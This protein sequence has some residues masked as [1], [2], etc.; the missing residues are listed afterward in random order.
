MSADIALLED[1]I[2]SLRDVTGVSPPARGWIKAIRE[3][4]GMT[5]AQMAR[6]MGVSQPRIVELE[7]GEVSGSISLKSLKRAAE[8]LDC[9]AVVLLVPRRRLSEMLRERAAQEADAHL[10]SVDQTMRLEDQKTGD[11]N[12]RARLRAQL[13]EQLMASPKQLWDR[14]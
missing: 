6:R 12:R 2:E 3:A 11:V 7:A 1:R 9:R 5:T 14:V 8:A 13:I 4:L 10:Q